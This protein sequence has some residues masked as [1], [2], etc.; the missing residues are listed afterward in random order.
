[1]TEV[2][3]VSVGFWFDVGGRDEPET[4]A[5]TSHFLEH[6]LFKGTPTR[7]AKDIADA[8]D[9][10]G[11][12]VNAFT[13]K[14]YTCYYARV[15]DDDLSMALDVLADM[16]TDS[17]LEPSELESERKVI[18]EEIAMHED[19]P[20]ELVHDLFYR[21]MWTGHP[22]GRPVLG[23]NDTIGSVSRDQVAGY[24]RERYS[25]SNLV[26]AAAGRVNHN[27][28]AS[29]IG[30]LMRRST[31]GPRTV[32]SDPAPT[33]L[34]GVK[35][36]KRPTEQAHIIIGSEGLTRA[37]DDRHALAVLDSIIGGGM[38]S[39]LFQEIREKRGLAYSVYSYRAMFADSGS[40][41]VYA[42]TTPQNAATVMD[43]V[44]DE[45]ASVVSDGITEPELERAKGHLKGS[46]VLAAED[47]GS[48]MN[49]L[50]KQQLTTGEI[51]SIDDLIAKFDAIDM[52]DIRRVTEAVLRSRRYQTTVIGPFEEDAFERYA[53]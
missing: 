11:G 32:R 1:M 29:Q 43:L 53:A 20:D 31:G 38:S 28:L 17:V 25:P 16:I 2:R 41:A 3:S 33:F 21:A 44:R 9:A 10:V 51:I 45:I 14:E 4:I 27:R 26:V 35:V 13:G 50:G 46:L 37:D 12:D 22:L 7:S 8:F 15:L 49:R 36:H 52:D 48:R 30:A 5:G 47:P 24:W 42:G 39:R 34:P 19:T 6:L 23:Y 18:L 40:F